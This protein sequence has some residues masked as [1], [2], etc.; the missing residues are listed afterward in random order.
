MYGIPWSVRGFDAFDR[1]I[2][3]EARVV[4]GYFSMHAVSGLLF[5]VE[6]PY[7][8]TRFLT[9]HLMS[10]G[11]CVHPCSPGSC[12]TNQCLLGRRH[13]SS[14]STPVRFPAPAPESSYLVGQTE[15]RGDAEG[16]VGWD[17]CH[18]GSPGLS[19]SRPWLWVSGWEL[20]ISN[21]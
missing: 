18:C 11:R 5:T 10:V 6:F 20:S 7:D 2:A 9:C 3:D 13:S 12:Y 16:S 19:L 8:E 17:S 1:K 4:T 14:Q 21:K 15:W